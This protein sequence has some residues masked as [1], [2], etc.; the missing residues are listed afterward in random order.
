MTLNYSGPISV[1]GSVSGQSI[2]LELGRSATAS[3][4]LNEAVLR[5]LAQVLS[6]TISMYNF[7]GKSRGGQIAFSNQT[8]NW[9]VPTGVNSICVVCI[10]GGASGIYT[11]DTYTSGGGGA[12]SYTN[13]IAVTPGEVLQVVAG[14]GGWGS[15]GGSSYIS[16]SGTN[17]ILAVGGQDTYNEYPAGGSASDGVGAFRYSGGDGALAYTADIIF[18]ADSFRPG[19]GG[20]AGY[21]GNGGYGSGRRVGNP[22]SI[23]GAAAGSGG[24]GGGG[25]RS[26]LPNTF[27]GAGGGGTG[28]YGYDPYMGWAGS[29]GTTSQSASGGGGGSSGS[30]GASNGGGGAYGGGGGYSQDLGYYAYGGHGAVRIIWGSGRAFPSTNTQ[31]I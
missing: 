25:G 9:T 13:N 5:S 30:G 21:S 23:V 20:A 11:G 26:V 7:Y 6:G 2:N 10:G 16:R 4:N 14:S 1:G 3:S 24:G 12:L 29:D 27:A 22:G 19:G 28:Y 8:T 18:P 31:D 17:L 15:G